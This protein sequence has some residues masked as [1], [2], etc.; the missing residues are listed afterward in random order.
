MKSVIRIN[1]FEYPEARSIVHPLAIEPGDDILT[2]DHEAGSWVM[3]RVVDNYGYM[4]RFRGLEGSLGALDWY[5]HYDNLIN[6]DLYINPGLHG[7]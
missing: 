1:G 5:E 2:W 3:A 4:I 6:S 7:I